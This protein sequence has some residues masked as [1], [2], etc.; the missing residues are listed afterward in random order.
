MELMII[1]LLTLFAM[2][3]IVP[4]KEEKVEIKYYESKHPE[5]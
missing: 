4:W 3:V 1:V 2:S 5:R